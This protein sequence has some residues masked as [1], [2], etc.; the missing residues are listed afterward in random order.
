MHT[1]Q[2]PLA[3]ERLVLPPWLVDNGVVEWSSEIRTHY[4]ILSPG[5]LAKARERGA[6][7]RLV[8]LKL[9]SLAARPEQEFGILQRLAHPHI[10]PVYA[11]W[12]DPAQGQAVI[13]QGWIEGRPA[14]TTKL[15]QD[16]LS[17]W[18]GMLG[19]ALQYLHRHRICHG[20]IKPANVM[21]GASDHLTLVD[22]G[23]ATATESP[24]HSDLQG[25]LAY[26][27]PERLAGGLATVAS[28]LYAWGVLLYQWATGQLPFMATTS[29]EL[30]SAIMHDAPEAP[31]R[32]TPSLPKAVNDVIL[33][34]LQKEPRDR[35]LCANDV[36]RSISAHTRYQLPLEAEGSDVE[37]WARRVGALGRSEL[38]SATTQPGWHCVTGPTGSGKTAFLLALQA[39]WQ[40]AGIQTSLISMRDRDPRKPLLS[41][42]TL[43]PAH[44]LIDDAE[45]LSPQALAELQQR[46]AMLPQPTWVWSMAPQHLGYAYHAAQV[47]RLDPLPPPQIASFVRTCLDLPHVD[48]QWLQA[49]ASFTQG[50]AGAILHTL[51]LLIDHIIDPLEPLGAQL[52]HLHLEVHLMG[53]PS[54]GIRLRQPPETAINLQ[55]LIDQAQAS[56][57]QEPK[58]R[59]WS[60][61]H[62]Q[63]LFKAGRYQELVATNHFPDH[64]LVFIKALLRLG[65]YARALTACQKAKKMLRSPKDTVALLNQEGIIH[66]HVGQSAVAAKCF[67]HCLTYCRERQLTHN[68]MVSLTNLANVLSHGEAPLL[69]EPLYLEALQLAH[70]ELDLVNEARGHAN[71]GHLYHLVQDYRR[72]S[73]HYYGAEAIYRRVR[74]LEALAMVRAN[75]GGLYLELGAWP[76]AEAMIRTAQQFAEERALAPLQHQAALLLAEL[77]RRQR[78]L[79][80][81]STYY[82]Q[83]RDGFRA[84]GGGDQHRAALGLARVALS[85]SQ[86]A[87]AAQHLA[88]CDPKT[89]SPA[90]Q[91]QWHIVTAQ[92]LI[93]TTGAHTAILQ[94]LAQADQLAQQLQQPDDQLL[95][96]AL[97]Q[98]IHRRYGDS[99]QADR[100]QAEG[101]QLIQA[102]VARV[103]PEYWQGFQRLLPLWV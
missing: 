11:F 48:P 21:I 61:L 47:H 26:L 3:H 20:D 1:G 96:R 34:L 43:P 28:D 24:L 70:A 59:A 2:R 19:R 98:R 60:R 88:R 32:H 97:L 4:E 13:V 66:F 95:I 58:N 31:Q 63:L 27:A 42:H 80:E 99:A 87:E 86:W 56:M 25:S 102:A 52:T 84:L 41:K 36:L 89:L 7:Q 15:S 73:E 90:L 79:A 91:V 29:S 71:L 8:A 16:Q 22:F 14:P 83:A 101:Q 33:A 92:H 55:P 69:V 77:C 35:P 23:F 51:R 93:A 68:L 6:P 18:I 46:M 62:L 74:D 100:C 72:A 94:H 85:E 38:V 39:Q 30:L 81:A 17:A 12:P 5:V 54:T 45:L 103:P 76:Q 9:V 37:T 78:H 67:R 82:Q 50:Q 64:P 10:V 65:D 44:C 57:M 53:T 40:A 49:L 75:L